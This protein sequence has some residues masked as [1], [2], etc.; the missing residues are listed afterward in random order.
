MSTNTPLNIR[1]RLSER[2]NIN[3]VD[4][5]TYRIQGNDRQRQEL[6]DLLFD[7]DDRVAYQAAWVFTH[8][9]L[10][11]N[12]WLFGKHQQL[13]DE[14]LACLHPG[15]RRLLLNLLYVQPIDNSPRMDFLDF[16]LQHMK[17]KDELPGVQT[18]CMKLA[19]EMCRSIPELLQEF[20][21]ILEIMEPDLLVPSIRAV[22]KNIFK[23]MRTGKSL[24]SY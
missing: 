20:R 7:A 24:Q 6:Y 5:I 14:V 18:L 19:W 13:V 3:D 11:E 23:A 15:K 21:A 10:L 8:F 2:I 16:C 1:E 17:S 12:R 4:E 9:S 22:R